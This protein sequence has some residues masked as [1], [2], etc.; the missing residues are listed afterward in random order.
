MSIELYNSLNQKVATLE[1]M[2][3]YEAYLR[4]HNKTKDSFRV[5]DTEATE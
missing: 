5:V 2:E 1:S 3:E 4:A